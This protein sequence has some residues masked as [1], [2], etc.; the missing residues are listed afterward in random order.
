MIFGLLEVTEVL[1]SG[2]ARPLRISVCV[3][4]LILKLMNSHFQDNRINCH[5]K[6]DPELCNIF[7]KKTIVHFVGT[8]CSLSR[9]LSFRSP[10][11]C[12]FCSS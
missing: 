8:A 7:A 3:F 1:W 4:F 10:P 5:F 12:L 9:A 2:P 11:F 6:Q